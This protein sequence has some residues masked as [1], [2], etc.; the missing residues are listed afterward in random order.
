ALKQKLA[1]E[2]LFASERKRALPR[3]PRTIAA[4]TSPGGAAIRDVIS[5][6]GRRFPAVRLV[7]VPSAVQGDRA[8]QELL[9]AL[10]A[11]IR[12]EPDVILLTR[13]G[14]SL[15]DLWAFNDEALARAIAASPIPTVCAVG[16]EV[17]FSIA[18]FV[19]DQ[20]AATPS[21]AAEL[22]VPD[23]PQLSRS[24]GQTAI[25]LE[26]YWTQ[27]LNALQQRRD[28]AAL[29]LERVILGEFRHVSARLASAQK[30]LE[31]LGPRVRL[32]ETRRRCIELTRRL[33][34]GLDRDRRARGERLQQLRLALGRLDPRLTVVSLDER[35]QQLGRRL[36]IAMKRQLQANEQRV[37]TATKALRSVSPEA[38]LERGYSVTT[39][40]DGTVI[41][42]ASQV[43]AGDAVTTRLARG[44]IE[45]EVK[46][47]RE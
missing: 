18:E 39:G 28:Q 12:L 33:R 42:D 21:A 27:T 25:R 6:L 38:V 16:H 24:L 14:G 35:R 29:R 20:R 17:D 32:K 13:G 26:R 46:R 1:A 45:S 47:A 7:V 37:G 15:E 8:P 10:D 41:R 19:A 30:R 34:R 44:S 5:V 9:A 11:A 40:A 3:F 43:A 36:H 31:G 22:L 23:G 4:V 2:G